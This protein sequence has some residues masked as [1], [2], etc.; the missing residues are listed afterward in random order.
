M[1]DKTVDRKSMIRINIVE[2]QR[3]ITIL[4]KGIKRLIRFVAGEEAVDLKAS[5][6]I[7]FVKDPEMQEIN[8]HYRGLDEPTDVLSFACSEGYESGDSPCEI[9]EGGV[10]LG[11][12]FI[13]VDTMIR[14]SEEDH[15][16]T[17]LE[18]ITLV[19]HGFLHLLGYDHQSE[20]GRIE[21]FGKQ[22]G[23][24]ESFARSGNI[25]MKERKSAKFSF[26]VTRAEAADR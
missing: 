22:D 21:M 7:V 6:S 17:W 14:N 5:C 18:L 8:R 11:D 9:A 25:L 3:T 24:I 15:R 13:S 12:I 1:K 16:E 20:V 10:E 2:K 26:D 23:Y 4:H 19:V